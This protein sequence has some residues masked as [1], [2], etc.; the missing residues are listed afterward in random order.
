MD[1]RLALLNGTVPVEVPNPETTTV[2]L[3]EILVSPDFDP[4]GV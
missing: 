3:R 4:S 2:Y 1:V